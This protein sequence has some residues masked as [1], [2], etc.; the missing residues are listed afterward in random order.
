MYIKNR[1]KTCNM[2]FQ[3]GFLKQTNI[4]LSVILV[5]KVGQQIYISQ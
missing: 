3:P 2:K 1:T 5:Q 4:W